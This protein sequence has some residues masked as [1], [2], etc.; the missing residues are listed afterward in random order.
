MTEIKDPDDPAVNRY[1]HEGDISAYFDSM[2]H[3]SKAYTKAVEKGIPQKKLVDKEEVRRHIIK[4]K[5]F[6]EPEQPNL[7]TWMEKQMIKKLHGDDPNEWT[8]AALSECFP[9]TPKGVKKILRNKWK[10]VKPEHISGHDARVTENWK[11]LCAGKLEDSDEIHCHLQKQGASVFEG[12][13]KVLST[14]QRQELEQSILQNYAASL[15][16]PKP[17][18]QGKFG[19]ILASYKKKV[20]ALQ[21]EAGDEGQGGR[22]QILP[23]K[24]IVEIKNLLDAE[25]DFRDSLHEP[26]PYKGTTLLNVDPTSLR[27]KTDRKHQTV[28]E[29]RN[30]YAR[31]MFKKQKVSPAAKAMH[32]W[33]RNEKSKDRALN[34][35]SQVSTENILAEVKSEAASR[36]ENLPMEQSKSKHKRTVTKNDKSSK[37]RN[38]RREIGRRNFCRFDGASFI[39]YSG[40]VT[41]KF[42]Q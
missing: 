16:P 31:E 13:T 23:A 4:K 26:S 18:L 33:L 38:F 27:S 15:E 9:V 34:M 7:L 2:R 35:P 39:D 25:S 5:Y 8:V 41:D 42:I 20:D 19:S 36:Y 1:H 37:F 14:A 12:L 24:N 28:D 40:A 3:E 11:L 10:S 29:F 17:L 21:L 30:S 32:D 6:P 22:A